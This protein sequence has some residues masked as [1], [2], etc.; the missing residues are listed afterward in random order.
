MYEVATSFPEDNDF[1]PPDWSCIEA[2]RHGVC[3]D[4]YLWRTDVGGTVFVSNTDSPDYLLRVIDASLF[5]HVRMPWKIFLSACPR[6]IYKRVIVLTSNEDEMIEISKLPC[7]PN[8]HGPEVIPFLTTSVVPMVTDHMF[9]R[10]ETIDI[11]T[12]TDARVAHHNERRILFPFSITDQ[13]CDVMRS[14]Q[15]SLISKLATITLG[16]PSLIQFDFIIR[17]IH[18]RNLLSSG[19]LPPPDSDSGDLFGDVVIIDNRPN[20]W[21]VL[22]LLITLDNVVPQ[23]WGVVVLCGSGNIAFMERHVHQFVPFAEFVEIPALSVKGFDLER[24]NSFLK[25]GSEEGVWARLHNPLALLVQDDGMLALP[26]FESA[27][28][29][30]LKYDYV[31]APWIDVM[32]NDPVKKLVPS[33]VG[34]GGLSLR[35]VAAMRTASSNVSPRLFNYNLQPIPEDVFFSYS[36]T[37]S[38]KCPSH[39]AE[40]FSVEQRTRKLSDMP[41]GFHKPWAYI[42]REEV[43]LYMDTV[44]SLKTPK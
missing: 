31:G 21:S 24:Y 36:V 2:M 44:I 42:Q 35:R 30:F 27:D 23:R 41:F 19:P 28:V 22:A 10:I 14:M 34:N 3:M 37:E 32:A 9:Y 18:V 1:V 33:L 43:A 17:Y 8:T 6:N 13:H 5:R 16:D 12:D 40:L 39:V 15:S 29:D 7:T 26:G 4:G 20:I 11:D 25:D 38:R